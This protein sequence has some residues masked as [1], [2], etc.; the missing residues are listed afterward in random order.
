MPVNAGNL[1]LRRFCGAPHSE[2]LGRLLFSKCRFYHRSSQVHDVLA[3][4]QVG[5]SADGKKKSHQKTGSCNTTRSQSVTHVE[6][7]GYRIAHQ[8]SD[9]KTRIVDGCCCSPATPSRQF[10]QCRALRETMER[11]RL[12]REPLHHKAYLASMAF[13]LTLSARSDSPALR[14]A[15]S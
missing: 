12:S 10:M 3:L 7:Y 13:L 2:Q 4:G 14:R 8:S 15:A 6:Q 1:H 11:K 5:S 9:I